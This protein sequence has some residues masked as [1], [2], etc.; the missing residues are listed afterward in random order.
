MIGMTMNSK[1]IAAVAGTMFAAGAQADVLIIVDL[2]VPNQV[3]L[4]STTGLAAVSAS[5]AD[6]IGLYMHNLYGGAGGSLSATLVS[7]NITHVGFPS[8]N[9]PSLFRGGAGSDTGLNLWSYATA[10]T[11]TFT[12]GTQAL[13]GS[14]T[15]TLTAAAY[16]DMLNGNASGDIYFPAD[17]VDDIA[18]AQV[19]GQ[20]QVIVPAPA[21]LPLLGIGLGM[22]A[23]R[24]RR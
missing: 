6:G 2:S 16:N 4:N 5:G 20:Y 7:G 1:I 12:A 17:T 14:G 11:V 24:R 9:T 22:G 10:S 8:D 18:S 23:M 21:T 13:Q 3:S 19:V 15:W